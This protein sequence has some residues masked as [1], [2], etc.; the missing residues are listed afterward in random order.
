[1]KTWAGEEVLLW[2]GLFDQEL[3]VEFAD[4][5]YG[6]YRPVGGPIPLH[7]YR[8]A[9]K[10]IREQR[11]DQIADLAE[12]ISLPRAALSGQ[13]DTRAKA[14]VI[15]LVRTPFNDPDP[16]QQL[17]YPNTLEA[18]RGIAQLL[19]RPLGKLARDDL[20]FVDAL[21]TRTLDKADIEAA[22]RSRFRKP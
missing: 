22:V 16:W 13:P 19:E 11:A 7:R 9:K 3:F 1:M 2:W 4:K 8:Q 18:R 6:P 21:L 20:Q 17:T 15:P 10:S 5:R 14:D 12:Q